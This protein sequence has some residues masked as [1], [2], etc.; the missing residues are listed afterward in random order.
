MKSLGVSLFETNKIY[1]IF[2]I[3]T[4][5]LVLV[6][7]LFVILNARVKRGLGRGGGGGGGGGSKREDGSKLAR[8]L[9]HN[10]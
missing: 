4:F 2:L 5:P 7:L 1:G 10:K 6:T 8:C 3:E 9:L